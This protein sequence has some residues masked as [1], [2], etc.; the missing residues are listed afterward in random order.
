MIST[1]E[2]FFTWNGSADYLRSFLQAHIEQYLSGPNGVN[3]TLA[4]ITDLIRLPYLYDYCPRYRFNQQLP[5][6]WCE[7]FSKHT[8]LAK[9]S[10]TMLVT[11]TSILP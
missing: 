9:K 8:I 6:L 1:V 2:L 7:H 3:S 4:W 11:T 5:H 10:S